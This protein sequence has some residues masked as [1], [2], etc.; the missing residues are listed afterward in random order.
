[1]ID[2]KKHQLDLLVI[3]TQPSFDKRLSSPQLKGAGGFDDASSGQGL[4]NQGQPNKIKKKIIKIHY[5]NGD[6]Y[7]GHIDNLNQRDGWGTYVCADKK[8]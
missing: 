8:K 2:N 7:E 4:S 3:P 1:M 5:T 6:I